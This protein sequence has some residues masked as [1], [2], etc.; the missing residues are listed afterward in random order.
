MSLFCEC[1]FSISVSSLIILVIFIGRA[2][3]VD[4]CYVQLMVWRPICV[5]VFLSS[6]ICFVLSTTKQ[7][8]A[9]A[10]KVL[11]Q[12]KWKRKWETS[13][14]HGTEWCATRS[15]VRGSGRARLVT[16]VTNMC[17]W[18]YCMQSSGICI[19]SDIYEQTYDLG[20][21]NRRTTYQLIGECK[22]FV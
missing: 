8:V 3:F 12:N 14:D 19:T 17:P 20:C 9:R 13:T 16:L 22:L 21:I 7:I 6:R 15:M 5:L 18:I 11:G 4:V 10:Q 1:L 2:M